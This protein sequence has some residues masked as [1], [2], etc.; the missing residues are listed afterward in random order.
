MHFNAKP[1]E[2]MEIKKFFSPI[3]LARFWDIN[4]ARIY[5]QE[6]IKFNEK[7][8]LKGIKRERERKIPGYLPGR[9]LTCLLTISLYLTECIREMHSRVSIYTHSKSKLLVNIA[10]ISVAGATKCL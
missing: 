5:L 6:F 8:E 4:I 2:M 3:S 10:L 7:Y 1:D 9:I